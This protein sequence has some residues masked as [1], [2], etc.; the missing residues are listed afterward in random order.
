PVR[1][2]LVANLL[3]EQVKCIVTFYGVPLRIPVRANSP[4]LRA[5]LVSIRKQLAAATKQAL[6]LTDSLEKLATD[7]DPSFK[8]PVAA[9]GQRVEPV[10]LLPA[11]A[12]RAAGAILGR[13]QSMPPDT[14][15]AELEATFRKLSDEFRAPV[16]VE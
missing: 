15:R 4:E 13:I 5:E 14:K 8:P 7:V 3:R 1:D 16:L 12:E 2:F 6:T 10:D 9:A 11:R